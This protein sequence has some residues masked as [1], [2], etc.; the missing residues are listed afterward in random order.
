MSLTKIIR[1][2]LIGAVAALYLAGCAGTQGKEKYSWTGTSIVVAGKKAYPA[3]NEKSNEDFVV[4]GG[5]ECK[6][7]DSV[8]DLREDHG[9]LTYHASIGYT[10]Y[11]VIEELHPK[12]RTI[13]EQVTK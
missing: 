8:W 11:L 1:N 5:K 13:E 3:S 6:H 9:K 12:R 2:T 4:W 7:Y 10:E